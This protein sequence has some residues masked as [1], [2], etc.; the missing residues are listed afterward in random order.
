MMTPGAAN[1]FISACVDPQQI[2]ENKSEAFRK[3]AQSKQLKAET[4][5]VSAQIRPRKA[6]RQ[7]RWSRSRVECLLALGAS[8]LAPQIAPRWEFLQTPERP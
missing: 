1:V 8:L 3:Q 6:T 7:V 2:S 5:P 4:Q